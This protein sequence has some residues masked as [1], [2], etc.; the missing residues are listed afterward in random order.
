VSPIMRSNAGMCCWVFGNEAKKLAPPYGMIGRIEETSAS[1]E[2]RSAPRSLQPKAT[3]A[4]RSTTKNST[5]M[6]PFSVLR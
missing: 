3:S 2:A 5:H 1:S 4:G 6:Q